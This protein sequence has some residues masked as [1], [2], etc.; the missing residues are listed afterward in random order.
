MNCSC[1][2]KKLYDAHKKRPNKTGLCRLC[3][4]KNMPISMRKKISI[5]KLAEKNPMWK[6]EKVGYISLHEWI[7]SR[8]PKPNKCQCC[9]EKPPIDLANIS[10]K[11]SRELSDWEWICRHCHMVKDGRINNLKQFQERRKE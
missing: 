6:G 11:Y 1:C 3:M 5:A 8:I 10:Q 9:K 7:K 4:N 2:D